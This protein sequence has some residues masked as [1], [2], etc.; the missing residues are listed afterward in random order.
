MVVYIVMPC[1]NEAPR[2]GSVLEAACNF[3][4]KAEEKT[5]IVVVDD[6]STDSSREIAGHFNGVKIIPSQKRGLKGALLTGFK[7]AFKGKADTIVTLDS[8][9]VG[10]KATH[11]EALVKEAKINGLAVGVMKRFLERRPKYFSKFRIKGSGQR[12]YNAKMLSTV[13]EN[14]GVGRILEKSPSYGLGVFL[15]EVFAKKFG[16]PKQVFWEGVGYVSKAKK[17]QSFPRTRNAAMLA[18]QIRYK[19]LARKAIRCLRPKKP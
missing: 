6:A 2:I 19:F 8:D 3:R 10:L 16:E 17:G 5:Q 15:F 1:K 13:L 7:E 9:L 18:K 4:E 11:I 14:S 12:A